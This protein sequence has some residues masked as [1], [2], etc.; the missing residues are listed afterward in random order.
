MLGGFVGG[1]IVAWILSLFGVD[2]MIIT[3]AKEMCNI[4][5][6]IS[7]YYISFA[8]IGLIGGAFHR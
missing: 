3:S 5:M 1:L 6:S 8:L 2:S 7:T 4:T